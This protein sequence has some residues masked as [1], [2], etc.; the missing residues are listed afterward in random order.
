MH[1][2]IL[3]NFLQLAEQGC[4]NP[5]EYIGYGQGSEFME[6]LLSL[7][8]TTTTANIEHIWAYID[9]WN[10]YTECI[11]VESYE[12]HEILFYLPLLS[13][14]VLKLYTAPQYCTLPLEAFFV[15]DFLCQPQYKHCYQQF[16]SSFEAGEDSS[17]T[18]T[19]IEDGKHK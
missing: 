17:S 6:F 14:E 9:V 1:S 16:I 5:T 8:T 12:P 10:E 3:D 11:G 4:T 15:A 18:H 2:I 19:N 7:S 13:A